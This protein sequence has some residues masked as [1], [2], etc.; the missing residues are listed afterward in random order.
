[1][2]SFL[3]YEKQQKCKQISLKVRMRMFNAYIASIFLYNSELWTLNRKLENEIDI[4]QR[5]LL[6][7]ILNI[8]YSKVISNEK[9]YKLLKKQIE[10]EN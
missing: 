8:K 1:M 10:S 4:F 9:L 5:S 2:A 3:N 6:R 7:K